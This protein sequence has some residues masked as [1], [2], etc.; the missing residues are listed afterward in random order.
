MS[1]NNYQEVLTNQATAQDKA[2][3]DEMNARGWQA[4]L[5]KYPL[6]DNQANYRMLLDWAN[7]L[8]LE[9]F[10]ALLRTK[11][12]GLSLAGTSREGLIEEIVSLS[13]GDSNA[14]RQLRFKLSTYSLAQLRQ[15]KHDI[16][17][18]K[19]VSTTVEARKYI[20]EQRA[21]EPQSFNGYPRL[22]NTIVPPGEVRA[23]NTGDY[24]R[25]IAKSDVYELKRMVRLFGSEQCNYWLAN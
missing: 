17:F 20:A 22:Q 16:E 14:L 7:P 8:T 1:G 13:Y 3:R 19:Q 2:Q 25:K 18:K 9:S 23:V 15:K 12:A 21:Q 11:P 10:E 4:I 5:N 6:V 24:M